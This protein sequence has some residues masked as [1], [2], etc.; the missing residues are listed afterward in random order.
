MLTAIRIGNFKAFAE[1]QRIPIR[2]VTLIY[3]AN[4][5]GKSSVLH[6][7]ILARH[8]QETGDL[9]VYLSNVGGEAVDLGGFRQYVHRREANRRVEWVMDLNTGAFRIALPNFC[10]G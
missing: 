4:S 7:L 8:A 1:T 9:D 6:S 5:S 10:S 2:P 3:G